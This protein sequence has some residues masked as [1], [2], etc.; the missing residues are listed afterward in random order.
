MDRGVL[1]EANIR[2][3]KEDNRRHIIGTPKSMLKQFECDLLK[4]DWGTVRDGAEHVNNFE[5]T[6]YRI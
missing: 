3:L 4:E 5:K 2:F 1:S 6:T